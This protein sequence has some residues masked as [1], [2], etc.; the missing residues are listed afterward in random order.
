MLAAATTFMLCEICHKTVG[1]HFI[2][3]YVEENGLF[4]MKYWC[5]EHVSQDLTLPKYER[6]VQVSGHP[7]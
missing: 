5:F 6:S 1:N 7:A 4:R 3:K 2:A